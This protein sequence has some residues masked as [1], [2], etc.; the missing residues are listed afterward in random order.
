MTTDSPKGQALKVLNKRLQGPVQQAINAYAA[1]KPKLATMSTPLARAI[2]RRDLEVIEFQ[3]RRIETFN[4]AL[5]AVLSL[6]ERALADLNALADDA[7]LD[8]VQAEIAIRVH[9]MGSMR[10]ELST[11]IAA[12]NRLQAK[13]AKVLDAGEA[14]DRH[15][16][17][18]LEK[19]KAALP[20]L[21]RQFETLQG[22]MEQ[23]RNWA[24]EHGWRGGEPLE[25][26]KAQ[27][28]QIAKSAPAD[29]L[30]HLQDAFGR[31][32]G[33]VAT[34]AASRAFT[35][36][37][38]N[39]RE[40]LQAGLKRAATILAWLRSAAESISRIRAALDLMGMSKALGVPVSSLKAAEKQLVGSPAAQMKAMTELARTHAL[41]DTP[42]DL[43]NQLRRRDL[44]A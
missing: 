29:E 16:D 6:V 8:P 34:D 31:I 41:S 42:K 24:S 38:L 35:E 7:S 30:A 9:S 18:Q 10:R 5:G 23:V 13:G 26:A 22:R 4:K 40:G 11:W 43:L 19:F 25:S 20:G 17:A 21:L 28:A 36:Q 12:A 27:A 14:S 1:V 39:E 33:V 15:V 44:V 2:R 37:Y 32:Q 3:S